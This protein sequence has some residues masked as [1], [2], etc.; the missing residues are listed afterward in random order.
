MTLLS[1]LRHVSA[2]LRSVRHQ[3]LGVVL[4]PASCRV[5]DETT[6]NRTNARTAATPL[7]GGTQAGWRVSE[8]PCLFRE[9]AFRCDSGRNGRQCARSSQPF[10]G[11][12]SE[13]CVSG[14]EST[15]DRSLLSGSP[16]ASYRW[17]AIL[18]GVSLSTSDSRTMNDSHPSRPERC[19]HQHSLWMLLLGLLVVISGCGPSKGDKAMDVDNQGLV[20][21]EIKEVGDATV[22][23]FKSDKTTLHEKNVQIVSGQLFGLVEKK[24]RKELI[25][26]FSNVQFISPEA[27]GML[28]ALNRKIRHTNGRLR[29]CSLSPD[30]FAPT[31]M[32]LDA[33]FD[34]HKDVDEALKA[35]DRD[36]Q[37]VQM[38]S[39]MSADDLSKRWRKESL[40]YVAA[41]NEYVGQGMQIGW[42]QAGKP[43][44]EERRPLARRVIDAVRE[45]NKMGELADLRERF[46][47]AHSPFIE[48]LEENGQHLA[49]LA[50]LDDGRI[51]LGIGYQNGHVVVIDGTKVERATGVLT[52]GRSPNRKYFAVARAESIDIHEGWGGAKIR[53]FDWPKIGPLEGVQYVEQV[54]PFPD[55]QR[56]VLATRDAIMAVEPQRT[57]LLYPR[58]TE[59]LQENFGA[60]NLD[61]PHAAISPEG[62]LISV[63]DKLACQHIVFNDQ[64]EVVGEISPLVDVAPCHTSFSGDG[65]LLTLSSFR[66][67]NSL[68]RPIPPPLATAAYPGQERCGYIVLQVLRA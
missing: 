66:L 34:I 37:D 16:L 15:T 28:I 13:V 27:L 19:L 63:G 59:Q 54:V 56:V 14:R 5:S 40:E 24:S 65:E 20:G 61:N 44:K 38:I 18:T 2:Q 46:P 3:R 6:P 11:R 58:D 10:A 42:D 25:L 21:L 30:I 1:A 36:W 51:V 39:A 57:E 62:S 43:P 45:A 9:R 47:P 55:G 26:D 52:F 29:L 50:L 67:Y 32:D 17:F 12:R 23:R 68:S 31:G 48:L 53:S 22:V 41:M 7:S 35:A 49:P 4:G 33:L 8:S 64:Y 60:V